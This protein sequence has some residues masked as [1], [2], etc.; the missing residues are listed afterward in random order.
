MFD[1][2]LKELKCAELKIL[3]VIIR[4][5]LGWSDSQSETGRKESDWISGSQLREKTGCSP[6]A[7]TSATEILI[8]KN[9]IEI[10]DHYGS[11][12]DSPQRR[13]GKTKLFYRPTS[14][15][16]TVLTTPRLRQTKVD[17]ERKT[18]AEECNTR[19]TSANFA[20]DIRKNCSELAQKMR[21]TKET[22]TKETSTKY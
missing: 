20:E 19:N 5:T 11:M 9:L 17:N 15:I 12:L 6:R 4:Q 21:I 3:L 10:S 16:F 2:F 13:K 8:Q 14:A 7:I 1:H 18:T 22:L